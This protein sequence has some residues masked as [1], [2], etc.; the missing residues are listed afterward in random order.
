M[1]HQKVTA[2]SLHSRCWNWDPIVTLHLRLLFTGKWNI[3]L[4]CR[5][6]IIGLF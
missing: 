3:L 1:M 6:A 2:K 4:S 5:D